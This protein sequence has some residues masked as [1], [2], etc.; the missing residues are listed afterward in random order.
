MSAHV[1]HT[2]TLDLIVAA[3]L[4]GA[5]NTNP[6]IVPWQGEL[7]MFTNTPEDARVLGQLL[8]DANVAS[9]NHRYNEGENPER[10]TYNPRG[11]APYLGGPLATWA[12]VLA[13]IQCYDYQACE[14]PGYRD[15]YPH[16]VVRA[17]EQRVI[18]RI[19]DA[20]D[21]PWGWTREDAKTRE[22]AIAASLRGRS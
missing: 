10:Y 11:I 7:R 8:L 6:L 9:V 21:A 14:L 16:A 12:D 19:I 5:T 22:D 2:D 20:A 3:A 15:N 13:A 18:S 1:V 17:I 4:H